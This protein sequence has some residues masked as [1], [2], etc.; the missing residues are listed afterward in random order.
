MVKYT[1]FGKVAYYHHFNFNSH[2]LNAKWSW[3][4][5]ITEAALSEVKVTIN[6]KT[7]VF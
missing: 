5:T 4:F 3:P 7:Q 2:S 1:H 6:H